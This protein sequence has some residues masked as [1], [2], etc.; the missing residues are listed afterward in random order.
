MKTTVADL[1]LKYVEA[2]GVEYVFGVPGTTLVPLLAAFNRNPRVKPILAKH[3]EGAAF[4]ADGY[5]R[6][7]GSLGVCFATSG[8]GATNLVSGVATAFLDDV[9][10][11]V[12]TGQVETTSYGKGTF[13]DSTRG[14]INSVQMFDTMTKHSAMLISKYK[15]V[16]EVR[17]AL[18]VALTGKRGPV[19]LSLPKDILSQEIEADVVAPSTYRPSVEY[20]DRRMVIEAAQQLV[21]AIRPA[22]LVGTGAVA[23]GACA[24]IVELAEMLSIPVATTPKA[25]GAFPED[26]PLA[27][28]VLGLCGSPLAEN[29][30][31]SGETDVLLVIGASLNQI[32]TMS[33]DPNLKPSRCLL[34][35]NIDPTEIGKNYRADIPLIGDARTIVNEIYFRVL[36]DLVQEEK[37]RKGREELVNRL[38]QEVGVCIEPEKLE[39]DS[40][41]IKP[42]RMVRELEEALP[43][44]AILF[45]DTGNAVCWAIHY[46]R[47]RRPN[48]FIAAFGL[49]TMGHG[50]A[51]AVGGKLAAGDRPVVALVGD[52]CFQM[53]GMEVATAV[54]YDIPVVWIVQNNAKLGLV[55]ELQKFSLGENT[56]ATTFK[57]VNLAKVAEGLGAVGYRISKPNEL[58]ELLPKAIASG[59]PTVIDCLVDPDEVP[60][61]AP[62]VQGMKNY[63]ISLDMI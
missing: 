8:P 21:R 40:V 47:F 57:E 45:V 32:T 6:V 1:I 28:G 44:D 48:S 62:F 33:W 42:Q 23:S 3:E 10:V 39:S 22:I 29:Y 18:R 31:K 53:N 12:L 2:E 52:G 35:I 54:N 16:D 61:L 20:F 26:H 37:K 13:Q 19:H 59:K 30:I 25:K 46:M 43:E 60:P 58:K 38:R 56:V 63:T 14:G 4:M 55:H 11:M 51:A 34:H 15:V 7:K 17:E 27:L 49:L 9:P 36:R 5:A 50:T 24:D 41:P